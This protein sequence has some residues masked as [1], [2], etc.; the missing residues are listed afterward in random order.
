VHP[1]F[2][3][4]FKGYTEIIKEQNKWFI[5]KERNYYERYW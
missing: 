5:V 2:N 3:E 4:V 1:I